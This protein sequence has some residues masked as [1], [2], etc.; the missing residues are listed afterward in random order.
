MFQTS[1]L[2]QHIVVFYGR[3]TT[4][5]VS[6]SNHQISQKTF[7]CRR[8]TELTI[9]EIF[10]LATYLLLQISGCDSHNL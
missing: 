3:V 5:S 8:S 9:K 1:A 2:K 10:S 7:K 6:C 4:R